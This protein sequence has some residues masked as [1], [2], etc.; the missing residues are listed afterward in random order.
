MSSA[1]RPDP[2]RSNGIAIFVL[3]GFVLCTA[4]FAATRVRST[5]IAAP[6]GFAPGAGASTSTLGGISR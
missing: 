3:V 4:L 5:G 6:R 1:A 2:R